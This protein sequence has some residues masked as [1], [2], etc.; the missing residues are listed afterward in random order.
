MKNFKTNSSKL[1][2]EKLQI[3]KLDILQKKTI[4]GGLGHLNCSNG[5]GGGAETAPDN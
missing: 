5:G 2:L 3:S 4:K 1:P